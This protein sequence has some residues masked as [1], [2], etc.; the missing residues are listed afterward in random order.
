MS[1][2]CVRRVG[3]DYEKGSV[4]ISARPTT[5]RRGSCGI[6]YI[7]V[8]GYGAKV[9][10]SVSS[11]YPEIIVT[12]TV[13]ESG[14]PPFTSSITINVSLAAKTGT[15]YLEA[16]VMDVAKDTILV[17]TTIPIFV[18]DNDELARIMD[19]IERYKRMY[20]RY[21]IQYTLL[22]I[23]AEHRLTLS[24]TNVKTLYEAIV[25]RKVSNGTVGDLLSR[26]LRKGL[27][28]KTSRGYMLNPEL[29]LEA[30]K[31][32]I[33]VKRAINGL[34]GAR[35]VLSNQNKSGV[36][37]ITASK[38]LPRNVEKAINVARKLVKEDYW[39]AVDFVAHTLLGV[40]RTGVWILWVGDYFIYK[41]RKTGFLH[42]FV[43][44][45]LSELLRSVGLKQ[46]FMAY[47]THHSAEDLIHK[48]YGSYVSARR[49]HYKLKERDWFEYGEP[50]LLEI[51][52]ATDANYLALRKLYSG[53]AVIELGNPDLRKKAKKYLVY[54]GEHIDEENEE[55]YFYGPAGHS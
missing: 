30:A 25:S 5:I 53:E 47:H 45:R 54:G 14:R 35:S 40:R 16:T 18:V 19:N 21:G 17:S 6:V 11:R 20:E 34:R 12:N 27:V 26:L 37:K 23:L 9:R 38:A 33:D 24:F 48:L 10:V 2:R 8:Q 3:I 32:I 44:S 52:S 22:R 4:S 50:L 42:Y 43:S 13:P 36:G 51:Y 49:L 41:E 28:V 29:D 31:S 55:T 7:R 46:G 1:A 15:Y 39:R